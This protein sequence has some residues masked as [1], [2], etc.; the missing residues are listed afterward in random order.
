MSA[1]ISWTSSVM[2]L[3]KYWG[4]TARNWFLFL[5]NLALETW[6][7]PPE[8]STIREAT[9]L[10]SHC[11]HG[12]FHYVLWTGFG[13][14]PAQWNFRFKTNTCKARL[15]EYKLYCVSWLYLPLLM[16]RLNNVVLL[17]IHPVHVLLKGNKFSN[18]WTCQSLTNVFRHKVLI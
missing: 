9:C 5:R 15:Q 8:E 18:F 11:C 14:R 3:W 17:W 10:S 2:V 12:T 1:Q 4:T 16:H 6:P 13:T 7:E